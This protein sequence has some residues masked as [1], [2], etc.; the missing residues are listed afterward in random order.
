MAPISFVKNN[1]ETLVE[2]YE[3][4][5]RSRAVRVRNKRTGLVISTNKEDQKRLLEVYET[6]SKR[7]TDQITYAIGR[8]LDSLDDRF[9]ISKSELRQIA[10]S[11]K[12]K[13]L[14][15]EED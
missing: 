11:N 4:N 13:K 10:N 14:L 6:I 8:G 5:G 9:L 2:L 15:I 3:G 12:N 1:T 7:E